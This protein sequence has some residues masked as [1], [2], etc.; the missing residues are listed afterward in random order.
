MPDDRPMSA[1]S[2]L[3]FGKSFKNVFAKKKICA[4][5]FQ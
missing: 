4:H 1:N 5:I 2:N 3:S